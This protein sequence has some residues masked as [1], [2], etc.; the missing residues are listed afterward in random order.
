MMRFELRFQQLHEQL[1][2]DYRDVRG[3]QRADCERIASELWDL[4]RLEG[5]P[6][7]IMWVMGLPDSEGR[8]TRITPRPYA[9]R[10]EPI[11]WTNHMFCK[12][13]DVAYDPM[14]PSPLPVS[15]YPEAAFV[16]PV[17]LIPARRL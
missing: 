9:E 16:E 6:A 1:A 15:E 10:A 3:T 14:L 17:I 5:K 2:D 11:R 8:S 12:L 7:E 4:L 13:A